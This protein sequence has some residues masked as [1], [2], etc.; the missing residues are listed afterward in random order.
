ML[1]IEG[2]ELPALEGAARQLGAAEAPVVVFEVHR[3]FVDWSNGLENADIIRVLSSLGYSMFAV[4]DI[5]SNY[6]MGDKPVELI[7]TEHVYLEGPPHGFNMVAV[8]DPAVFDSRF[9]RICRGVSPKLL[10]HKDPALHH[11]IGGF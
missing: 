10:P 11:P 5:Q 1:D 3:N 6:A 4:R 2:A 7:P 8:G 9:F